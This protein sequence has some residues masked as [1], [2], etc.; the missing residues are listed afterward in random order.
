MWQ[1]LNH[2]LNSQTPVYGDGARFHKK[3]ERSTGLGDTSNNSVLNFPA[4]VGTHVDA[5]YHF[6]G[7]GKSLVDYPAD[8]W[9]CNAPF[10]IE[11]SVDESQVIDMEL[12]EK[13]FKN[14]PAQTDILLVKTGFEKYRNE[15]QK[16]YIFKN[17]GFSPD[18]GMWLRKNRNIKFIGFDFI[19]LSGYQNRPLGRLAHKAFLSMESGEYGEIKNEPPIL[20]IEDMKLSGLRSTP[21]QVVCAPLFF[22]RADGSPVTVLAHHNDSRNSDTG[23]GN[24]GTNK[25]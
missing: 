18:T 25:K 12:C 17:P 16:K 19:S 13:H 23:I 14:I 5:P 15:D 20:I 9:I 21:D 8:F 2:E 1:Y 11:L 24:I 3:M 4:H 22:D 6:D 10:L 7:S